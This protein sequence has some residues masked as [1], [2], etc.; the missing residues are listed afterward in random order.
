MMRRETWFRGLVVLACV[1]SAFLSGCSRDPNVRK[2]KYLE[3]GQR[4]YEKGQ[5]REAAIQFQNAIQVDSQFVDAHY[6]MALTA[7]KLQQ[8][9]GA[10]QELNTTI[11][12]NPDHYAA[13]LELAKFLIAAHEYAA[14]KEHLDFLTQKQ[15]DNPEVYLV[16]SSYQNLGN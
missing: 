16:L 8:Y 7:L 10:F 5:Y 6:S 4:F 2:H 12:L 15:P 14:A 11:Q 1:L 13:R 9:E 3:S